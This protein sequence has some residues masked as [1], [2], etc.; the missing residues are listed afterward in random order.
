MKRT[1]SSLLILI[2]L[3]AYYPCVSAAAK[4]DAGYDVLIALLTEK[5]G[6]PTN[7]LTEETDLF[8]A[9]NE[10]QFNTKRASN[11]VLFDLKKQEIAVIGKLD[12]KNVKRTLWQEL[13]Y[14]DIAE[15]GYL[16]LTNYKDINTKSAGCFA[17]AIYDGANAL[18]IDTVAESNSGL[19]K[20]NRLFGGGKPAAPASTLKPTAKPTVKPTAKPTPKPTPKTSVLSIQDCI[21]IARFY[22]SLHVGSTSLITFT[23][24]SSD[25]KQC[26]VMFI[27]MSGF[28]MKG[29]G[30]LVDRKTGDVVGTQ[31]FNV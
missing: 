6:E 7:V 12:G 15:A 9:L 22:F 4:T 20:F 29:I 5:F 10:P 26:L 21:D 27:Y 31:R 11:I 13:K 14:T 28:S 23:D 16:I 8:T 17:Y 1:I 25:E 24:T 2:T 18:Y 30:I 19:K 3:I